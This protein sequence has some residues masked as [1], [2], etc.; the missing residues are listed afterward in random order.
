MEIP[1]WFPQKPMEIPMNSPQKI[2]TAELREVQ[3]TDQV[4][5]SLGMAVAVRSSPRD[6][7][8]VPGNSYED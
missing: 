7:Y 6:R 5:V 8:Y 3:V 4:A 1:I 2:R